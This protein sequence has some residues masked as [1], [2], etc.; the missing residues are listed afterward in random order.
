M[1]AFK[2]RGNGGNAMAMNRGDEIKPNVGLVT[3]SFLSYA[4]RSG[5]VGAVLAK[6]DAAM[7]RSA[8]EKAIEVA[9]D[10]VAGH[11]WPPNQPRS[12]LVTDY[13]AI[14]QEHAFRPRLEE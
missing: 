2:G 9:T 12:G 8:D 10:I 7:Q 1:L 4:I 13:A 5:K 11:F 6:W 14:C 3:N